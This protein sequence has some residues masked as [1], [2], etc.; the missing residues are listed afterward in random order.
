MGDLSGLWRWRVGDWRVV[1]D[2]SDELIVIVVMDVA[3]RSRVYR[4]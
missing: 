2:I 4:D 3:H 1:A